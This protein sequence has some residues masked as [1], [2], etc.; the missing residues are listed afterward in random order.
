MSK[1]YIALIADAIASRELPPAARARLQADARTA[2]KH[3]NQRYRR[4]LAARFAVTLGDELQCLLPTPQPVWD[5]AHDLRA[6]LP[7]VDWVVAC[8]RGPIT[9]PLAPT[10]PAFTKPG[11]R[12][13]APSASVWCSRSA[14]SPPRSSRSPATMPRCTGAGPRASGAPRR[15]YGWATRRP[16]RPGST[17]IAARS[18][19][20]PGAWPGPSWPPG[21]RC[22]GHSWRRNPREPAVRRSA[23]RLY[24][25]RHALARPGGRTPP[26]PRAALR[27]GAVR[28]RGTRPRHAP[29]PARATEPHRAVVG[30]GRPASDRLPV[31][32]GSGHRPGPQRARAPHVADAARRGPHRRR[33]RC[34]PRPRGRIAGARPRPHHGP[35]GRLRRGGVDHRRQVAGPLQTARGPRVRRVLSGRHPR[36]LLARRARRRWDQDPPEAGVTPA[37]PSHAP[38]CHRVNRRCPLPPA[39]CFPLGARWTNA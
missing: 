19:T 2:V 5:V 37:Q 14:A 34:R 1:T 21:I 16:P 36:L 25:G 4:V 26:R 39:P 22:F 38:P 11:P 30:A 32:V 3:L 12:W 24:A 10:A 29:R 23:A 27:G 8:G 9:T 6:R 31:C 17:S 20:S 15:C 13:I 28:D 35:A 18:P 7:S 33:D